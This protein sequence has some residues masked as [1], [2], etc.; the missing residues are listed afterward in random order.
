MVMA[1]MYAAAALIW[2]TGWI[3]L[4]ARYSAS[5]AGDALVAAIAKL[6]VS[7]AATTWL[8]AFAAV[9]T[10]ESIMKSI[11]L[12]AHHA[13]FFNLF[14]FLLVA[15]FLH[16]EALWRIR[17]RAPAPS[18]ATTYRRLWVLSEVIPAPFALTILLTGLRLIW[19]SPGANSPSQTWLFLLIAAF[20]VFFFDGILG[21]QPAVRQLKHYWDAAAEADTSGTDGDAP[22]RP[23]GAML[24]LHLAAFPPVFLLALF[25]WNIDGPWN[26]P[27]T[28]IE[29]WLAH[30]P[31]GWPEVALALMVWTAA[32]I[33]VA[34][35]RLIIWTSSRTA[36]GQELPVSP[37]TS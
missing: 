5:K 32:G 37:R 15:Q 12:W 23:S 8:V 20:S 28:A 34:G 35:V 33:V 17:Q 10:R 9:P 27:L 36:R 18:V 24:T 13:G 1:P 30:L 11:V 4:G 14:L 6:L 31:R 7:F 29:D 21:Y 16:V 2:V 3:L 26:T 19:E 22:R 25:R